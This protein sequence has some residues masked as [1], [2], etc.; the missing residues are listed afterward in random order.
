MANT[1]TRRTLALLGV[2]LGPAPG[3]AATPADG[4]P[5][6]ATAYRCVNPS[7]GASW[8]MTVDDR[9]ATV[10]ANPAKIA[11]AEISWFDPADSSY[12]VFDRDSGKLTASIASSTGG[13]FRHAHCAPE[14][15]R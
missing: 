11:Q 2:L 10:D 4:G 5:G 12:N 9:R 8:R 13:Y 14:A 1:A 6:G 7:S 3:L 15:G